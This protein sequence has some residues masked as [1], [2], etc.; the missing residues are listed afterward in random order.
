MSKDPVYIGIGSNIAPEENIPRAL[1]LL[2][3]RATLLAVS[4]LYRTPPLE[5]P[6]QEAYVN[7]AC[8][9]RTTQEPR[10]LKFD[11]LRGIEEAMGR[12]RTADKYAPRPIDLDIALYGGTV[13][14]EEDLRIPDPDIRDRAFLAVPLWELAPDATLPDTGETLQSVVRSMADTGMEP[15]TAYTAGLRQRLGL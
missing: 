10:P 15:M 9:I 11:T 1:E 7:G 4:T 5:R 8:A 14:D 2:A 6:G 12:A 3:G 13:L